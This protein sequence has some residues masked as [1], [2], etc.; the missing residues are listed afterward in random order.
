MKELGNEPISEVK[1]EVGFGRNGF[2]RATLPPPDSIEWKE[3]RRR[4]A[5]ARDA[6][7]DPVS[8]SCPHVAHAS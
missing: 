4:N 6:R 2:L 5:S 7:G 8:V 3:G 1:K